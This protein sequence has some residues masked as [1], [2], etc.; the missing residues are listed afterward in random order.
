VFAPLF[1]VLLTDHFIVRRR[2]ARRTSARRLNVA[3]LLAWAVGVAAYQAL[4]RLAPEIGAT[5]PA[6]VIAAVVYLGLH[7]LKARA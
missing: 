3:G 5:L 4:S 6:F 7:R 1:G 2:D